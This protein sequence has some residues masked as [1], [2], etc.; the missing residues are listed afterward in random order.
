[1]ETLERIFTTTA[2]HSI[3]LSFFDYLTLLAFQYFHENKVDI[4]SLEVGLGGRMDSTNVVNPLISIITSISLDHTNLLG[5]TINQIAGKA[6]D[7]NSVSF[8]IRL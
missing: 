1:M 6:I 2:K 3:P 7:L 5:N 4:V 8:I